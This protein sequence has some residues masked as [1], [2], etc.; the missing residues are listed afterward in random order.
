MANYSDDL[1]IA[2]ALGSL[3]LLLEDGDELR[4]READHLVLIADAGH[5]LVDVHS[6]VAR[7][8]PSQCTHEAGAGQ[9]P[10]GDGSCGA[11]GAEV[12]QDDARLLEHHLAGIQQHVRLFLVHRRDRQA[13]IRILGRIEAEERVLAKRPQSL[14]NLRAING[15][16]ADGGS[17]D[18]NEACLE[19][20]RGRHVHE[21]REVRLLQHSE[22]R[23]CLQWASSGRFGVKEDELHSI[24]R[25]TFKRR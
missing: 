20:D 7:T 15:C 10:R 8:R 6:S 3:R 25:E 22:V 18:G 17:A 24:G 11:E 13:R 5:K 16:S 23:S 12:V 2:G 14:C 21:G 9:W 19:G 4:S 1:A